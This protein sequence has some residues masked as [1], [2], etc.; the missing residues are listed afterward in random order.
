MTDPI[1]KD[2]LGYHEPL[3]EAAFNHHVM[4]EIRAAK[5]QRSLIMWIFTLLGMT[6]STAYLWYTLPVGVMLNLLTPTNGLLL[7]GIG[8]FLVWLWTDALTDA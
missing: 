2:L 8:L 4:A 1:L 3:D 5:K 6:V 7:S